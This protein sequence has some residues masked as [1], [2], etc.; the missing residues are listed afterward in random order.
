MRRTALWVIPFVL[1]VGACAPRRPVLYPNEQVR[2]VG[3][4]VAE[5]DID[6]CMRRA[7]EYVSGGARGQQVTRDVAGS[8][9][10]GAGA[11]AA[12][13]A[14]G[15]AVTGNAGE[16]AAVGAATGGTA[17]LL[18]GIFGAFQSR[19]PDPVYANFVD[20]CLRERGYDPI[21]WK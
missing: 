9:A 10:I 2:R 17:G 14:V 16:G 21:G 7:S 5:R 12:I 8:T 3:G 15:G 1:S 20:R 18:S 19:D 6:E 13:G 4:A 11:G